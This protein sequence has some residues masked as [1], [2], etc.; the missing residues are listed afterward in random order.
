MLTPTRVL[1]L[2]FARLERLV[3]GAGFSLTAH[4]ITYVF[5]T[6]N[7]TETDTWYNVLRLKA[8]VVL[9][10]FGDDYSMG[11]LLGAGNNARVHIGINTMTGDQYAIKTV[12]KRKLQSSP[13]HLVS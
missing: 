7:E 2:R 12:D 4:R 11:P 6:A 10:S 8:L 1:R 9:L 13:K 3:G 5:I